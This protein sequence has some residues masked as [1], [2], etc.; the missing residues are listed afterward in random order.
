MRRLLLFATALVGLTG[1]GVTRVL[2]P[3]SHAWSTMEWHY[4]APLERVAS[5]YAAAMTDAGLRRLPESRPLFKTPLEPYPRQIRGR[6]R[7]ASVVAHLTPTDSG[8]TVRL[9][10]LY[11]LPF[12]GFTPALHRNWATATQGH[13][14]PGTNATLRPRAIWPAT[15]TSCADRVGGV[16][17][18]AAPIA[19]SMSEP[20]L[21]RSALRRRVDGRTLLRLE[22]DAAGSVS[23]AEALYDLSYRLTGRAVAA[24]R[25]W[26]FT[27]ATRD[28]LPVPSVVGVPV[29]FR[30]EPRRAGTL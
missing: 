2:R 3:P 10:M 13:L 16:P 18:D 5:A 8:T 26:R 25:R 17:V 30:Y 28:G 6:D 1:C 24:A 7:Y 19:Q 9:R 11:P 29:R 23:C 12:N 15:R 14:A 20:R 4:E 27:P 22:V 21:T